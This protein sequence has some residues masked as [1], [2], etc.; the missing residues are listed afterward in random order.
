MKARN[1]KLQLQGFK[2][3][4]YF[5]TINYKLIS[6][7]FLIFFLNGYLDAQHFKVD[8]ELPAYFL[9]KNEKI[10]SAILQAAEFKNGDNIADVG[11]GDGLLDAALS[12]YT[13]SLNFYLEDIDSTAYLPAKFKRS[14][15]FYTSVRGRSIS[16]NFINCLGT[17]KSTNL[18]TGFIDKVIIIDTYH[19]FTYPDEMIQD[20]SRIMKTG[21]ELIIYEVI[22]RKS[23]DIHTVCNTRVYLKKELTSQVE[24]YGFSFIRMIKLNRVAKRKTGLFV[25]KKPNSPT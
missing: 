5:V 12:I 21:G 10:I 17:E 1:T 6:L 11:A 16:N 9:K 25:F 4:A 3:Q 23:G 20:I 24:H 18:K 22:A 19:H 7:V 15:Q 13:D 14:I 8:P 2:K